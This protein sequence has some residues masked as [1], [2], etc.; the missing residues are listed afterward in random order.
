M[1]LQIAA[2]LTDEE[3]ELEKAEAVAVSYPDFLRMSHVWLKE[4]TASEK[5][6]LVA[7]WVLETT[8]GR[9]LAEETKQSHV[10]FDDL[11]VAEIGMTIQDFRST[12]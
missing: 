7:L 3:V 4:E 5:V 1:M 12:R 2:L 10:D 8:I 11:I 9:L 6:I